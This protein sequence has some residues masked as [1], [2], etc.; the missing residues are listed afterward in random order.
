MSLCMVVCVR[1]SSIYSGRSKGTLWGRT[2]ISPSQ[3]AAIAHPS[4]RRHVPAV[5]TPAEVDP[6]SGKL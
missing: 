5:L 3:T 4:P 2:P 6:P 1:V